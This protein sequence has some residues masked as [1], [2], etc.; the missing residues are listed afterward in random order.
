[1]FEAHNLEARVFCL[2]RLGCRCHITPSTRRCTA[3][4]RGVS[5]ITPIS[6]APT[7]EANAFP[8]VRAS[9]VAILPG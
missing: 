9:A 8:R 1:M 2:E 6:C 5:G 4:L 7:S 3:K